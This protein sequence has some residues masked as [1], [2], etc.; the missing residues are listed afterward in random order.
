MSPVEL[1]GS[2]SFVLLNN[3]GGDISPDS[4]IELVTLT[5]DVA[6]LRTVVS[7]M[8]VDVTLD[9]ST[10]GFVKSQRPQLVKTPLVFLIIILHGSVYFSLPSYI[11]CSLNPEVDKV[12]CVYDATVNP[13]F[14]QAVVGSD[15]GFVMF[16]SVLHNSLRL[17]VD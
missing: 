12:S 8:S 3:F 17:D 16:T 14:P 9:T 2:V 11:H 4:K 13:V 7:L 5:N 15:N 6:L 1:K 10:Y